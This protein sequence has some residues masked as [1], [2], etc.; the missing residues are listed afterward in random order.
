LERL[1]YFTIGYGAELL[2]RGKYTP[3]LI[4]TRAICSLHQQICLLIL[5]FF[6]LPSFLLFSFLLALLEGVLYLQDELFY[7]TQCRL[8]TTQTTT[9]LW[10]LAHRY[11]DSYST[12][13]LFCF[14]FRKWRRRFCGTG[15]PIYRRGVLNVWEYFALCT[16]RNYIASW[17]S[18]QAEG[19]NRPGAEQTQRTADIW[20]LTGR[21]LL[22][23]G[24]VRWGY[25]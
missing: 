25:W 8:N 19:W 22:A 5:K 9:F 16:V 20:W 11:V 12:L 7:S 23:H 24:C 14:F 15:F 17:D 3:W 4:W 10:K 6:F 13:Y 18:E 2:R 1:K 21:D